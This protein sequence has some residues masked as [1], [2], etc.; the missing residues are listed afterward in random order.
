MPLTCSSHPPLK[1]GYDLTKEEA[2]V[3]VKPGDILVAQWQTW[4]VG[5]LDTEFLGFQGQ[6][7]IGFEQMGENVTF[8]QEWPQSGKGKE[9]TEKLEEGDN[10]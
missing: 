1:C 7:A 3:G 6:A 9:A 5:G 8:V 2:Q 10:S 4:G